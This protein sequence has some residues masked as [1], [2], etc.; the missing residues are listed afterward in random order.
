[1][2]YPA[3]LR[4]HPEKFSYLEPQRRLPR[5]RIVSSFNGVDSSGTVGRCHR[6]RA[7]RRASELAT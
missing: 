3:E 6:R 7:F 1:M 2:L 4:G 5:L